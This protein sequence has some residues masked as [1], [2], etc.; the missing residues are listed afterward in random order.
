MTSPLFLPKQKPKKSQRVNWLLRYIDIQQ[1][2]DKKVLQALQQADVDATKKLAKLKGLKN[3][4]ARTERYQTNLV[5]NEI[6]QTIK[7]MYKDL[8]PVISAGQGD[9]AEAAAR[10]S[11][12]TDARVLKSLFPNPEDRKTW[13]KSFIQ[14]SRNGSAAMVTRIHV[15]HLP[16][17]KR[18]YKTAAWTN[19]A[20]DRKINSHLA[21]GSSAEELAKDI[22]R[23]INPSTPGGASYAAMRL[24]R[25]EINNA[26]HAMSI[27]ASQD[28]PWVD[29]VTW[30]L[31]KS[32]PPL[33]RCMC[34]VYAAQGVFP[35]DSIPNKPHPQCLCYI[36]TNAK[37]WDDF[38]S[39]LQANV[40]ADFQASAKS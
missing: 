38:A 13:R 25:S 27:K 9:A 39:Q 24:A 32:H 17:S 40:F 31:S 26:F 19:N 21:R 6:R 7:D 2:Y 10:A 35:V 15:S 11:L 29:S 28:L 36:V 33:Q 5:R 34:E 16:L 30:Y 20:L 12:V 1:L 3:I 22:K 14:T 4:G 8:V 37:A 23:F 18:V